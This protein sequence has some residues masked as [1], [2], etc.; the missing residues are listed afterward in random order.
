MSRERQGRNKESR[1][2]L[3]CELHCRKCSSSRITWRCSQI[4]ASIGFSIYLFLFPKHSLL[5]YDE[6][7]DRTA[8]ML[9]DMRTHSRASYSLPNCPP[10]RCNLCSKS[11]AGTPPLPPR[12]PQRISSWQVFTSQSLAEMG[13][14][15]TTVGTQDR[16]GKE[17]ESYAC[18]NNQHKNPNITIREKASY[19]EGVKCFFPSAS[20]W[21]TQVLKE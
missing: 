6:K 13:G 21:H 3:N 19:S 17:Y 11:Q 10:C 2:R 4:S 20:I 12:Q 18:Q 1:Q 14:H 16:W 15:L 9:T 7:K 5:L 8:R